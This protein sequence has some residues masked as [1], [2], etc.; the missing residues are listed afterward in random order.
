MP[1]LIDV[2]VAKQFKGSSD[3]IDLSAAKSVTDEAAEILATYEGDLDLT[4]LTHLQSAS[5][6]TKLAKNSELIYFDLVYISAV[7]AEELAKQISENQEYPPYLNLDG[8]KNPSLETLVN[9]MKHS[10]N[11]FLGLEKITIE[12]A[13]ILST[14]CGVGLGLNHVKEISTDAARILSN[15]RAEELDLEGLETLSAEVEEIFSQC[16]CAVMLPSVD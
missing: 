1:T 7:A 12:E 8:L 2:N 15:V 4:N 16:N 11:L 9:L 3:S 14:F 13:T 10:G 5:L 6:A